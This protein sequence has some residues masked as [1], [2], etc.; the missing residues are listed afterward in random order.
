MML[1]PASRAKHHVPTRDT[2]NVNARYI[3]GLGIGRSTSLWSRCSGCT[4][5]ALVAR[6]SSET[7]RPAAASGKANPRTKCLVLKILA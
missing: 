2:E 1:I 5:V 3:S 7:T 6:V 4:L